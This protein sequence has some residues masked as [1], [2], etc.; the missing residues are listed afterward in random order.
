[1]EVFNQ[2]MSQILNFGHNSAMNTRNEPNA[3]LATSRFSDII[4]GSGHFGIVA[5]GYTG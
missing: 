3:G 2:S 1:M 4:N 5:D